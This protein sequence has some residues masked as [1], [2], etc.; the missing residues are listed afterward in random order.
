MSNYFFNIRFCCDSFS[1]EEQAQRHVFFLFCFFTQQLML[2]T[3]LTEASK[4]QNALPLLH[5]SLSGHS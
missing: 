5:C 1:I 4:D 3:S 2:V